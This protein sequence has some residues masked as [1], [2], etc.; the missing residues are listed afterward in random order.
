MLVRLR[1]RIIRVAA[2]SV[3]VAGG[4]LLNATTHASAAL[5]DSCNPDQSCTSIAQAI[6][7]GSGEELM[8]LA[9][10][11]TVVR[12]DTV[13]VTQSALDCWVANTSGT[14]LFDT[15]W[16]FS[17]DAESTITGTAGPLP[18]AAYQ[19]CIQAQYSG[20]NLVG[21]GTVSYG[22]GPIFCSFGPF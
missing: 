17:P 14:R 13:D 20:V 18:V 11:E 1:G 3:I 16:N 7:F 9:C 5:D 10:N 8:A 19:V 15:G 4:L 22:P 21:G 6:P 12:T 2:A